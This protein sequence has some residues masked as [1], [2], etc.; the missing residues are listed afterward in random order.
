MIQCYQ[1]YKPLRR[2]FGKNY[3]FCR[4]IANKHD[5]I[6]IVHHVHLPSN[7]IILSLKSSILH[8]EDLQKEKPD[9]HCKVNET[10][11]IFFFTRELGTD[12]RVQTIAPFLLL[13]PKVAKYL[14]KE[15]EDLTFFSSLLVF[16]VFHLRLG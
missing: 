7:S 9:G 12:H 4:S 1:D 8:S 5:L 10:W 16:P 14:D 11:S 3:L 15:N 6:I 13:H 2:A